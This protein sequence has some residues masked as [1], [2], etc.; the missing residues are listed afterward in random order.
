MALTATF[1][2]QIGILFNRNA[3]AKEQ[4]KTWSVRPEE[5]DPDLYKTGASCE[6]AETYLN[7]AIQE[8]KSS[9]GDGHSGLLYLLAAHDLCEADEHILDSV[10]NYVRSGYKSL[11]VEALSTLARKMDRKEQFSSANFVRQ[12]LRRLSGDDAPTFEDPG[13][14]VHL[15]QLPVDF[16]PS[17]YFLCNG[18]CEWDLGDTIPAMDSLHDSLYMQR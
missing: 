17:M 1:A 12:R 15:M 18:C 5:L 16:P 9:T 14:S 2:P 10:D 3:S 6:L 11:A 8:S 7:M 4:G 13:L